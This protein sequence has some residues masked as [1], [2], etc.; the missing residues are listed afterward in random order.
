MVLQQ[1]S[2]SCKSMQTAQN[3]GT[4]AYANERNAGGGSGFP[5]KTLVL[6]VGARFDHWTVNQGPDTDD[7]KKKFSNWLPAF[8]I[9]V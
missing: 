3:G 5:L 1:L 7:V 4:P 2:V 6:E 9:P 8:V